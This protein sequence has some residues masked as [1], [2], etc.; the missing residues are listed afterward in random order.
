[1]P[2]GTS[3]LLP[4]LLFSALLLSGGPLD[5]Q[6]SSLLLAGLPAG[7][8]FSS[9]SSGVLML[10]K[11]AGKHVKTGDFGHR[12]SDVKKSGHNVDKLYDRNLMSTNPLTEQFEPTESC[13]VHAHKRMAGA[14]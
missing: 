11:H 8:L 12:H 6:T 10:R 13:P 2:R 9:S 14:G 7:K 3:L 4:F 1:M 5:C